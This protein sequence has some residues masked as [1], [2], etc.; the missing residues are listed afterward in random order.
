M[1]WFIS[2]WKWM[3]RAGHGFQDELVEFEKQ[4]ILSARLRGNCWS[5]LEGPYLWNRPQIN[6]RKLERSQHVTGWTWKH[7]DFNW[8]CPKILPGKWLKVVTLLVH[9]STFRGGCVFI[10]VYIIL[11]YFLCSYFSEDMKHEISMRWYVFD[12]ILILIWEHMRR[13]TIWLVF[14]SS[15]EENS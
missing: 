5:F 14:P 3:G 9:I 12:L 7:K 15:R 13:L 10:Q 4:L 6:I 8:L 11:Y 1:W 2:V